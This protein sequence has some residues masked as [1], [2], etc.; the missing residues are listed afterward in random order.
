MTVWWL[1]GGHK[2]REGYTAKRNSF[3]FI[4]RVIKVTVLCDMSTCTLM[5]FHTYSTVKRRKIL[6]LRWCVQF[7]SIL[8]AFRI[9]NNHLII[10]VKQPFYAAIMPYEIIRYVT[11]VK[12][13]LHA[14]EATLIITIKKKVNSNLWVFSKQ[15]LLQ[16]Y[17]EKTVL[18]SCDNALIYLVITS[19]QAVFWQQ[20]LI[21]FCSHHKPLHHDEEMIILWSWHN[22]MKEDSSNHGYSLLL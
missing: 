4:Y 5:Y 10:T 22:R 11:D 9:A 17:K 15:K 14:G 8:L 19:Q 20:R 1:T 12:S 18:F 3:H 21:S 2:D 13:R 6:E 7:Q 16:V